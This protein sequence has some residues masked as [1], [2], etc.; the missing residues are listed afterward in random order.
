M[1]PDISDKKT[2]VC[3]KYSHSDHSK[4]KQWEKD[5][6]DRF[7]VKLEELASCLPNYNKENPWKKVEI[8]ENAIVNLRSLANEMQSKNNSERE[9]IRKLSAEVN[10]LKDIILQF[11]SFKKSSEDIYRLTSEEIVTVIKQIILSRKRDAISSGDTE[12]EAG[13][14]NTDDAVDEDLAF[15]AKIAQTNDHCYSVSVTEPNMRVETEEIVETE[16]LTGPGQ[17]TLVPV[18]EFV[19]VLPPT[20]PAD[21]YITLVPDTSPSLNI[22]QIINIDDMSVLAGV[23]TIFVNKGSKT[24]VICQ[25]QPPPV[26]VVPDLLSTDTGKVAIP[27]LPRAQRRAKKLRK[28]YTRKKP[29]V[30]PCKKASVLKSSVESS[31]HN[32]SS[33]TIFSDDP[34]TNKEEMEIIEETIKEDTEQTE[35]FALIKEKSKGVVKGSKE[36]NKKK[37]EGFG[38]KKS[39]SSY[40]IAAL[41]QISV[42]IGDNRPEVA[43]SPGL[44]SLASVGTISPANTPGPGDKT[45][46]LALETCLVMEPGTAAT[47]EETVI[48]ELRTIRPEDLQQ[49]E[50]V[51]S[52]VSV[53]AP[54]LT[55]SLASAQG[56]KQPQAGC[57]AKTIQK[58]IYQVIK[59]LDQEL[60]L[61]KENFDSSVETENSAAREIVKKKASIQSITEA[62]VVSKEK[63]IIQ[64]IPVS[65]PV[66]SS[67]NELVSASTAVSRTVQTT[68]IS[69]ARKALITTTSASSMSVYDFQAS[70]PETP[71]IPLQESRKDNKTTQKSLPPQMD[72]T[73]SFASL[74]KKTYTELHSKQKKEVSPKKSYVDTRKDVPASGQVMPSSHGQAASGYSQANF[75]LMDPAGYHQHQE[76]QQ[77]LRPS[78]SSNSSNYSSGSGYP[79]SSRHSGYVSG[80]PGY[81]S[82][83]SQHHHSYHHP[84]NQPGESAAAEMKQ[85]HQSP[86]KYPG[87][88]SAHSGAGTYLHSDFHSRS[89]YPGGAGASKPYSNQTSYRHF[90]SEVA[91]SGQHYGGDRKRAGQHLEIGSQQIQSSLPPEKIQS[92][93]SSS[94]TFSVT[95]LVNT[96][97]RKG[98]KRSS[99]SSNKTSKTAKSE[100][101]KETKAE[102]EEGRKPGRSQSSRRN[103]SGTRSNYS[104]E[105]LISGAGA[106][107]TQTITMG[108]HAESKVKMAATPSKTSGSQKYLSTDKTSYPSSIKTSANWANDGTHFSGLQL[109]SP[110][111]ANIL[112][113]DLSS[114]DFQMSI[115]GQQ[116]TNLNPKD[117][118]TGSSSSQAVKSSS[119]QPAAACQLSQQRSGVPDWSLNSGMLETSFPPMVPILTPPSDPMTG[120]PF[121][122]DP[123]SH[124]ASSWY[125]CSAAQPSSSSRIQ[126]QT[127]TYSSNIPVS[128]YAQTKA[129]SSASH[130]LAPSHM[131]SLPPLAGSNSQTGSLLNFNLSTI[132][133][134]IITPGA[135]S[136]QAT[137]NCQGR[138]GPGQ[139]GAAGSDL[140]PHSF[141]LL[142]HTHTSQV[143]PPTFSSVTSNVAPPPLTFTNE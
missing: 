68:T 47:V 13:I 59:D 51:T 5:R 130:S 63:T 111:P 2:K 139:L 118:L 15:V 21:G 14:D 73:K 29:F 27:R 33:E 56:G 143:V 9:T 26:A 18:Q 8:V 98:T 123:M 134:D 86:S 69:F 35:K 34:L 54:E 40:S 108:E 105:S 107:S 82:S 36:E 12:T 37:M 90:H 102:K 76:I 38:K 110:S 132:F 62:C 23:R 64:N 4:Y 135:V 57:E 131:V 53:P 122:S 25:Q 120:Y 114:I 101:V 104:A 50:V 96:N 7:N 74:E 19:T 126:N 88:C 77:R 80:Y 46:S 128:G 124:S 48:E 52:S 138:P 32:V 142:G 70:K 11:T 140:L 71:P 17:Q 133:P 94:G 83:S 92:Q 117:Y 3:K 42:N 129:A 115:F 39:K 72:Q 44:M 87:G 79:L 121:M 41:C 106:G 109:S 125:P 24:S 1:A 99:S 16:D 119:K 67:T 81:Q 22:P 127:V 31:D 61:E 43:Q 66:K 45:P 116:D 60:D 97:Q 58:D 91:D 49:I 55:A 20:G 93:S 141:A 136:G 84:Y 75:N 30:K 137:V 113:T 6:R 65:M 89:Y 100:L 78:N 28:V 85:F 95:H 112:P 10:S 103:K